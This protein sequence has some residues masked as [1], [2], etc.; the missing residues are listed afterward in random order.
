MTAFLPLVLCLVSVSAE[1]GPDYSFPMT[2]WNVKEAGPFTGKQEMYDNYLDGCRAIN[3]S[4]GDP[5]ADYERDRLNM[6]RNQ[7][8]AMQVHY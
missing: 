1:Y 5:C 3:P 2:G 8:K 7:P 4:Q 6:N